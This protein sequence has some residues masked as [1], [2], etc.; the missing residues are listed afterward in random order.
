MEEYVEEQEPEVLEES[1]KVTEHP[2]V[3]A[4]RK[5]NAELLAEVKEARRRDRQSFLSEYPSLSEDDIKGFNPNQ[6]RELAKKLV[7]S[8][9]PVAPTES[10]EVPPEVEEGKQFAA[11]DPG[12]AKQSVNKISLAEA[13]KI[14]KEQGFAALR[15]LIAA[16]KVEGIDPPR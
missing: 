12:N 7:G 5:K 10:Q 14:E 8:A 16:G 9:T 3:A 11:F 1:P 4:L 2:E 6:L 13:R 15:P